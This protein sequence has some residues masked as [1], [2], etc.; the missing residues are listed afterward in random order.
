MQSPDQHPPF[1]GPRSAMTFGGFSPP[2]PIITLH[3]LA[4]TQ[5]VGLGNIATKNL[6][7]PPANRS[8]INIQPSTAGASEKK[9]LRARNGAGIGEGG[10]AELHHRHRRVISSAHY[11]AMQPKCFRDPQG[12]RHWAMLAVAPFG[13]LVARGSVAHAHTSTG[14]SM[15]GG[16]GSQASARTSISYFLPRLWLHLT[17]HSSL[18][19]RF[20]LQQPDVTH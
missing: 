14:L 1:C 2:P 6:W 12:L 9:N 15:S 10:G 4:G 11:G 3:S 20:I 19:F 17:L 16:R 5:R 7:M 18:C 13:A 8:C